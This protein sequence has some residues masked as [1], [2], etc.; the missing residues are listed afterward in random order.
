MKILR[1]TAPYVSRPPLQAARVLAAHGLVAAIPDPEIPWVTIEDLGILR[2]VELSGGTLKVILT[3]TY[4]N[5]PATAKIVAAVRQV[6]VDNGYSEARVELALVPAW[7]TDWISPS[8]RRKLRAHGIAPPAEGCRTGRGR[9][10]RPSAPVGCPHCGSL[11]TTVLSADGPTPCRMTY[12]CL[13]C[14]E[15]FDHMKPL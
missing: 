12:R 1:A 3:P 6:L 5:C 8:G 2:S 15:P 4:G 13:E 7:S 10:T 14:R 11:H 9:A